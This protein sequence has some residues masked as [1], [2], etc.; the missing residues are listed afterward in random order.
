MDNFANAVTLEAGSV[1]S[2]FLNIGTSNA[3]TLT[4][5]GTGTQLYSTAVTGGT[6][7]NGA[8][9]KN[10]SGTWTLDQSFNYTG[11]TT[12]NAGTLQ[13]GNGGTAGSITGNV[14]D[15]GT[16]AFDR[17]DSV[18]FSGAIRGTGSLT[19]NGS[20]TLVLTGTNT[21]GGG[22]KINAGTL[23]IGSGSRSGSITGD[24]TDNGTLAFDRSDSVTFAGVISGTGSLE[25]SGPGTLIL[26][27]DNTFTGTTTIGLISTLQLGNGRTTGTVAGNIV[28][29]GLLS[30][31]RSNTL[32][33]GGVISGTGSVQQN[34]AGTTILSGANTYAG[35][36]LVNAGALTVDNPQALGLGSVVVDGGILNADPQPINVTGN[37]TQNAGGT[38]ELQ[39]AGTH[40]GQY[41]TL[42]VGGNSTLAGTLQLISL[43]FQPKAGDEL[44]LVT[45]GGAV[46]GRFTT[47][48]NPFTAGNGV[49]RPTW[50]MGGTLLIWTS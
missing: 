29:N 42:N 23:Q 40:P 18:T 22:T 25:Q 9:I 11:G 15:N 16:L 47:F 5:D 50:S 12:I 17:S 37:Y 41:D 4:L 31:N 19:Q 44:T 36:T 26:T 21:Y 48:L 2:G 24:V 27:A 30:F 45:A 43:G 49:K 39:V 7:F 28:D 20:G 33:I 46:S 32:D 35:G 38:L 13:I 3:A 8:L 1:I 34:G 10:G 6:A 14:K